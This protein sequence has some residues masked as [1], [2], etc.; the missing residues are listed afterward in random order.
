MIR[1]A[2]TS[3][4]MASAAVL[5]MILGPEAAG[6]CESEADGEHEKKSENTGG[7]LYKTFSMDSRPKK[8]GDMVEIIHF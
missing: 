3:W 8:E 4:A 5:M 1:F 6:P 7:L 2:M